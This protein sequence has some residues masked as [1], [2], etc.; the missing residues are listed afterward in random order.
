MLSRTTLLLTLS[1]LAGLMFAQVAF[2]EFAD[3][4]RDHWAYD[5]VSY[6]EENGLVTGY[7]DG[8]F[9]GDRILNRYEFA[10]VVSRLYDQLMQAA[11]DQN[12][13][14]APPVDQQAVLEMLMEE[15]QP[16][17]DQ[18]R[19][20]VDI[21]TARIGVVESTTDQLSTKMNDLNTRISGM[22]GNTFATSGD[23]RVRFEGIYP[24]TGL[25]TQ[26]PRYRLRWGF[27]QPISPELKFG[28][29]LASG[30]MGGITSTNQT[31]EKA[32]GAAGIYIDRAYM[33]YQPASMPG[34][35]MWAGKFAPPWKNT[36]LVWD[37]DVNVEGIAQQYTSGDFQFTLG[38]LIPT[39]KG[40]YIV[41]QAG[42]NNIGIE[43]L[44]AFATYHWINEDAWSVISANMQ[45]PGSDPN[46]LKSNWAW[47]R[48]NNPSDYRAIEGY[49]QYKL[50]VSSV[51]ITI[52][53]DYLRNLADS[54]GPSEDGQAV[55]AWNQAASIELAINNAPSDPGQWQL[56]GEWGRAQANSVLTWLAD[57]DRGGSDYNW[58]VAGWTYRLLHNTDFAITYINR[59]RISKDSSDQIVQVDV[60]T[61]F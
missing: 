7:P 20:L 23:I 59:D 16:D 10:M 51:P 44:S 41:A 61:K 6:L 22:G 12:R 32:F 45:L 13:Q 49:L 46:S 2:A 60:T 15:F 58:W 30:S 8:T 54:A 19:D 14:T 5:A 56:K 9:K 3:V 53:A 55:S 28:A 33:Q 35:T 38:E 4:P 31:M 29:R 17:I 25:Q 47:N 11:N 27:V 42:E 37:S 48:L 24:N 18:L 26:R 21:N 39:T 36:P 40:F 1:L 50:D 57:A 34:L 52:T 43:G